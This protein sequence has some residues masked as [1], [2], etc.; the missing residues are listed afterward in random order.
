M[1]SVGVSFSVL[2]RR[3]STTIVS[4]TLNVPPDPTTTE[5]APIRLGPQIGSLASLLNGVPLTTTC[6]PSRGSAWLAVCA[7]T[8]GAARAAM[9]GADRAAAVAYANRPVFSER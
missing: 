6:A 9:V 5:S 1:H 8:S 7:R 2:A 3:R 4:V